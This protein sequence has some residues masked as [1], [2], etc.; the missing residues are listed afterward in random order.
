MLDLTALRTGE[1]GIVEKVT[2]GK[3]FVGRAAMGFTSN[4]EITMLHNFSRGPLLVFLW[5]SQIALGR[6]E[7]QKIMVR[8]G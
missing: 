4:V 2:G 5:D 1:T 6:G 3:S 7:A 8:R